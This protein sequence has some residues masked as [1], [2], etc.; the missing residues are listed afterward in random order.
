MGYTLRDDQYWPTGDVVPGHSSWRSA[1]RAGRWR[2]AARAFDPQRRHAVRGSSARRATSTRAP[3]TSSATTSRTPRCCTIEHEGG[4]V[5]NVDLD[6][7]RRPRSRGAPLEAF[8]ERGA[9]EVTTDFVVGAPEDSFLIQRPDETPERVDVDALR[10]RHFTS[11][12]ITRRDFFFYTY[13]AD[14]AWVHAVR[15][16]TPAVP[17]FA[18]ALAAHALVEAAYR[19]AAAGAPVDLAGDLAPGVPA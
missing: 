3:A 10:D 8:F 18:D 5:G 4:V 19:S 11:L 12:G 6:L 16:G 2:R 17:G 14:R 9:V 1:A 7:Q 13:P 15:A